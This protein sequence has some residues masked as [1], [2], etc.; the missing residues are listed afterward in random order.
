MKV[1]QRTG[2]T[3]GIQDIRWFD[4][5][6]STGLVGYRTVPYAGFDKVE[7][8]RK[9]ANAGEPHN[10]LGNSFE[11]LCESFLHMDDVE[12]TYISFEDYVREGRWITA[13]ASNVG[14]VQ[15]SYGDKKGSFKARK[16]L[17]TDVVEVDDLI[18]SALSSNKQVNVALVK[19]ELGKLRIAVAS[20]MDTYLKMSW[21]NHLL[22]QAY[23]TWKGDTSNESFIGT[24][25]R[26][27]DMLLL[28]SKAFGLPFDF[29]G[30]DHQP[31]T[32][33]LVTIVRVM[34]TFI[35][36]FI[37]EGHLSQF[38]MI[39]DSVIA[40]FSNSV[41][42][43]N[44]GKHTYTF[45]QK[46]GLSSG[47]RWTSLLG[48]AWN[49]VMTGIGI[50]ALR[51]WGLGKYEIPSFI[52]GDDS[53]LYFKS[54]S[55]AAL[56]SVAYSVVGAKGG[57]GKFS[58]Q[59]QA[60]EFLR[61][62]FSDRCHGYA[63]RVIPGLN[64]R[65]PWSNEPWS[66]GMVI[67]SLA[68]VCRILRRRVSDTA[69]LRVDLI[70]DEIATSWCRLHSLPRDYLRVPE[71]RG[72]LGVE[73]LPFGFDIELSEPY[74]LRGKF[75]VQVE[76]MTTYRADRQR[77]YYDERY[78]I[79]VADE[80]LA[81]IVKDEVN[82]AIV[83]DNIPRIA[84]EMRQKLKEQRL[85][86]DYKAVRKRLELGAIRDIDMGMLDLENYKFKIDELETM[87]PLF[88]KHPEL[89][90]A[91]VDYRRIQPS[92][93]FSQW[94]GLYYPGAQASLHAFHR[95]W[96]ISEKLDY[97]EGKMLVVLDRLHPMLSRIHQRLLAAM[98]S[99]K[100]K[101]FS[102]VTQWMSS[103]AEQ[104]ILATELSTLIYSW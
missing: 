6:E 18:S 99:T 27:R 93:T 37:P 96:H 53:A 47:L 104:T 62:W 78:Q 39:A 82:T 46:G 23:T 55:E 69:R 92:M 56:M 73:N 3:V 52:R 15:W 7:E 70:W 32:Y 97:L 94:L 80:K 28:V 16:N 34:C 30:F 26:L 87:T 44:D 41:I 8:V 9:L 84:T 10:Y 64:Q 24:T 68:E 83:T 51:T 67:K 17:V 45:E 1:I 102:A 36:R 74:I 85:K 95:S 4:Y 72:G 77:Q 63:S 71:A 49:I 75:D 89:A 66:E 22:G 54:W 65:K 38:R 31:E 50:M 76:N 91:R 21:L 29:E 43:V 33:E 88:G 86:T 90:T 61:V 19:E 13:G 14:K 2:K 59:Y 12:V 42:K 11:T 35:E 103:K 101:V 57:T 5:V 48:I 60:T 25:D 58:V 98:I 81:E 100:S 79:T 20:D 40:G